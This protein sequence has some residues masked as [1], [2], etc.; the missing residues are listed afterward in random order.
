M[1]PHFLVQTYSLGSLDFI[2]PQRAFPLKQMVPVALDPPQWEGIL[3]EGAVS[4]H[5]KQTHSF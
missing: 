4:E 1:Q 2:L 5:L 3:D